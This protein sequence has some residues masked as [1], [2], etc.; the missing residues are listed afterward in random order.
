MRFLRAKK[1]CLGRKMT[2][3]KNIIFIGLDDAFS[4]WRF[5]DAFGARLQTPN[6]DRICA[7]STAFTSAYCQIAICGPSCASMMSGLS[8]Y[9]TGVFDNYTSVFDVLR[10]EQFWQHRIKQAGYYCST[11]GKIHHMFKPL[12]PKD[13]DALYS[14]PAARVHFGPAKDTP[15]V[16][17][18]GYGNGIGTTEKKQTNNI[19]IA[20]PPI[21]QSDSFEVMINPSPSTERSD[22]I[23]HTFHFEPLF[24]LR[25]CIILRSLFSQT[26]GIV[27]STLKSLRGDTCPKILILQN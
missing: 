15:S 24:A 8:P 6:L 14:H 25:K 10:P 12:P 16:N 20:V 22:F 7:R 19:M 3:R 23:I 21:M 18:G 17:F 5:R 27:V 26:I 1:Y 9:E 2:N 11:A 13:H 4:F